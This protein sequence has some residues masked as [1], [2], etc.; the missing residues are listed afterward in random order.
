[1]GYLSV[2]SAT[3]R[4]PTFAAVGSSRPRTLSSMRR[5]P[6]RATTPPMMAGSTC[7]RIV[8]LSRIAVQIGGQSLGD[9]TLHLGIERDRGRHVGGDDAALPD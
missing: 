9:E 4:S 2:V 6:T 8:T 5:S 3:C 1:M 7:E